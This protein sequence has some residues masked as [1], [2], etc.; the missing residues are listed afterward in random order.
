MTVAVVLLALVLAVVAATCGAVLVRNRRAGRRLREWSARASQVPDPAGSRVAGLEGLT[1]AAP[2]RAFSTWD[3]GDAVGALTDRL[4]E[5]ERVGAL[6][7]GWIG[8]LGDVI[9]RMTEG[10]VI[11]DAEGRVLFRD[12]AELS[13][14]PARHGHALVDAA[15]SRLLNRACG[16]MTV[17]E[18]VRLHGPP[19]RVFMISASPL[20]SGAVALIED[21][22]ERERVETMRRDFVSNVSHELRTPV[23]AISLLAETI[24]DLLSDSTGAAGEA[25][26]GAEDHATVVGLAARMVAEAERMTRAI[27]D[28]AELSRVER[29]VD[30]ERSVLALQDVVNAVVERLAN[31]A[32]QCGI[33]VTVAAPGE[34]VLILA[35]RRQVASAVHNLLDN[36]IKYSPAGTTVGM[37]VRRGETS[38]ELAVQ[39]RGIGIPRS[40][41]PRIFE[42]FYRVD[43]SRT[44]S[45]GGIGL[46]LAIVRHVAINHGGDVDVESMEGEGSTF[47]LRLPLVA[48]ESAP[49][50]P[51]PQVTRATAAP[52]GE[53]TGELAGELTGTSAAVRSR[54][55]RRSA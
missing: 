23:G 41:L 11:S 20:A 30:G 46:G 12:D 51:D 18:E 28:L 25:T 4:A 44:S 48:A 22:T 9:A 10:V 17:R 53:L 55:D 42:R 27:D 8:R 1:A 7:A 49:E 6:R 47:T 32:E 3:L 43:R 54:R 37:R 5:L 24:V 36:A 19:Q 45:S 13:A 14:I 40:D 35:D 38:A 34:P 50:P 15:L 52:V 16:G 29:D 2:L 33:A 21:V 26:L 39:D 31:A